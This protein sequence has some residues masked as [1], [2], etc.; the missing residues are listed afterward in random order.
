MLTLKPRETAI[1]G[2]LILMAL[3]ITILIATLFEPMTE[4]D[5]AEMVIDA[6]EGLP[7]DR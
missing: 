7:Q 1:I 3:A 2:A 5:R 4:A 6:T